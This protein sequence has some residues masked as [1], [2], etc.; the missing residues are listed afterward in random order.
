MLF[1]ILL[2]VAAG[3][4]GGGGV[5]CGWWYTATRNTALTAGRV[6]DKR[7]RPKIPGVLRQI[8][9]LHIQ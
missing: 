5:R 8:Y 2:E 9:K 6:D 4:V 7:M 1:F 3:G